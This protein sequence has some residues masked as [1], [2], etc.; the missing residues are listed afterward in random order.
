MRAARRGQRVS[1]SRALLVGECRQH[2]SPV[3]LRCGDPI[4][5]DEADVRVDVKECTEVIRNSIV[6]DLGISRLPERVVAASTSQSAM[7]CSVSAETR[8]A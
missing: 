5:R 2:V 4:E 8:P 3:E 7:R 1:R 6:P